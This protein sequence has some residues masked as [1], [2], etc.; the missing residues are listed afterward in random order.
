[1][2]AKQLTQLRRTLRAPVSLIIGALIREQRE[3][4]GWNRGELARRCGLTYHGIKKIETE[5]HMLISDTIERISTAL[6]MDYSELIIIGEG[7][8]KHWGRECHEC[9]YSC[10]EGARLKWWNRR[11]GCLKPAR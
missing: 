11:R 2:A 1:M 8:A 4:R 5:N 3:G 7:R 6:G 9:N 10:I